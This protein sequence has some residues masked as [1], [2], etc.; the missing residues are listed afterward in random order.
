MRHTSSNPDRSLLNSPATRA[1]GRNRPWRPTPSTPEFLPAPVTG[2]GPVHLVF[3]IEQALQLQSG[4]VLVTPMT[5]PDMV[6]AMR[7]SA[8][9]V[10]DVGGIICH[11]AIVSREI[12]SGTGELRH[13]DRAL[14]SNLRPADKRR[15]E[16][17]RDRSW[18][19][20]TP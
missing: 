17:R 16:V 6:V 3:N 14:H 8:A 15:L 1:P 5:N 2:S 10:T 12:G 4:S 9:I 20:P 18:F 7:N 11:A 19:Q 13:H